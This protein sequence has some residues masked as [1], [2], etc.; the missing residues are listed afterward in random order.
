[1][2]VNP[3]PPT[4]PMTIQDG[5]FDVSLKNTDYSLLAEIVE[6]KSHAGEIWGAVV[7]ELIGKN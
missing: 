3:P 5:K 4:N 1:M 2:T 6:G 7:V